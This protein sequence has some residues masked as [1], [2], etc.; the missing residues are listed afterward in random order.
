MEFTPSRGDNDV[1]FRPAVKA[2]GTK[3]YEYILVYT[4]DILVLSTDPK[5]VIHEIDR[6]FK[7]V[8]I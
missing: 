2:D 6:H 1:W 8:V 3:Y 4:D 5:S 7:L